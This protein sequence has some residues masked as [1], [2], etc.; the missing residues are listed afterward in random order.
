MAIKIDIN[1]WFELATKMS[2]NIQKENQMDKITGIFG[3]PRGGTLLALITSSI[4]SKPILSSPIPGCVVVDDL[5]DSGSTIEKYKDYKC[6]YLIDKSEQQ[7]KN[8]WIEF[9]YEDTEKDS[10]DIVRRQLQ[11]IGEDTKR[12]GLRDTP[13][14]VVKM[15]QELFYGYNKENLPTVTTFTNGSDGIV[16]DE[17]INDYGSFVSF[18]EH[19]MVPFIGYYY[20]GYIPHPKGKILGLSKVSRVVDYYSH[21]LQIQERLAHQILQY[22]WNELCKDTYRKPIGVGLVLEAEHLCK[23]IR[24]V[25]KKGS[26]RTTKL[27]GAL[28]T[29]GIARNEFLNWVNIKCR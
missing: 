29:N 3:I 10:L 18:C 4:L 14:R 8:Q 19:H 24:G 16:Y 1:K 15:W 13:K 7:Y 22:I 5:K 21:K 26:M 27:M 6:Y 17:M 20:F 28:K 9:W 12:E 25:K 23:T 2:V 11:F